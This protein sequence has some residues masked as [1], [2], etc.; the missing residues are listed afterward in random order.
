MEFA[1][2]GRDSADEGE[3]YEMDA[4]ADGYG[5]CVMSLVQWMICIHRDIIHFL[6]G[7]ARHFG[8]SGSCADHR[9]HESYEPCPVHDRAD[10]DQGVS[11]VCCCLRSRRRSDNGPFK[12]PQ[13]DGH[14]PVPGR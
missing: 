10:S 1:R 7:H 4:V 14:S 3:C 13:S 2:G 11:P 9:R 12:M 8:G 5:G 6:P